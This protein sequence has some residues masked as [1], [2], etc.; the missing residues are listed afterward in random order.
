MNGKGER[1]IYTQMNAEFQR[2]VKGGKK[3]FLTEQARK[4]IEEN[5]RMGKKTGDIKGTTEQLNNN[6]AAK[7]QEEKKKQERWHCKL[8]SSH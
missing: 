5:N 2:I 3:A 7:S 4:T 8:H 6:K 1:E